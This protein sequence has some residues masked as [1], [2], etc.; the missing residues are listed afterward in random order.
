[1]PDTPFDAQTLVPMEEQ[2]TLA[3]ISAAPNEATQFALF[4]Y[5]L[6]R[7]IDQ[8][9]RFEL[10]RVEFIK[11]CLLL[12]SQNMQDARLQVIEDRLSA[13]ENPKGDSMGWLLTV[14]VIELVIV[15]A[16]ECV[17]VVAIPE[18]IKAATNLLAKSKAYR[19]GS[20]AR[21]RDQLMKQLQ[22]LERKASATRQEAAS[23]IDFQNDLAVINKAVFKGK[24]GSGQ[25]QFF[26]DRQLTSAYVS[27]RETITEIKA[28]KDK[29]ELL[30]VSMKKKEV[31][32]AFE[33]AKAAI[34]PGPW[35]DF[36]TRI[37]K[38]MG[39]VGLSRLGENVGA[40]ANDAALALGQKAS[41]AVDGG[42]AAEPYATFSPVYLTSDAVS[43][44]LD[45]LFYERWDIGEHFSIL[46]GLARYLDNG[47]L[48]E[49][50]TI[51]QYFLTP[52]ED[53]HI[54]ASMMAVARGPIVASMEA[55]LWATYLCQ[56]S[57]LIMENG[58]ST[59]VQENHLYEGQ[60][61]ND[62]YITE[63]PKGYQPSTDALF[64]TPKTEVKGNRYPGIT[65]ISNQLADY[66]Y[67]KF[68][69]S[70]VLKERLG[71]PFAY[72]PVGTAFDS[73]LDIPDTVLGGIFNN[74]EREQ[75]LG[76]LKILVIV[77]FGHM[78][79][80]AGQQSEEILGYSLPIGD[81]GAQGPSAS[82]LSSEE[83]ARISEE[84]L[85]V[86]SGALRQTDYA[87]AQDI[88]VRLQHLLV[89]L[90]DLEAF[91]S[92]YEIW[93]ALYDVPGPDE[94][95]SA[96]EANDWEAGI[97]QKQDELNAIYAWFAA[98]K[99]KEQDAVWQSIEAQYD[100]RIQKMSGWTSS[101]S[102]SH[103][104]SMFDP[105]VSPAPQEQ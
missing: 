26:A 75:M 50:E 80:K 97:K 88:Q 46:R 76:K 16:V 59:T 36:F 30:S 63:L 8:M 2:R 53:Y 44:L 32:A 14:F 45:E 100:A 49:H 86:L 17:F 91:I 104:W 40:A 20:L 48:L 39:D 84:A 9:E 33:A 64:G 74:P 96:Q 70:Y 83:Q 66:L 67:K 18:A 29:I 1:M 105:I 73:V 25:A 102:T 95:F 27:L 72:D 56:S 38:N 90:T 23:I 81:C 52:L 99:G 10:Q 85:T 103:D 5:Y 61:V 51:Q 34:K 94:W 89:V 57:A 78:L 21:E 101:R 31:E 58:I 12:A 54:T 37:G 41:S 6:E 92:D 24:A 93:I 79:T 19:A 87:I 55:A 62:L 77:A 42:A 68:A 82:G 13:L 22:D 7:K 11:D 15:F 71:L 3:A 69:K 65:R 28:T 98:L 35:K 4:R 47:S 60:I 43:N